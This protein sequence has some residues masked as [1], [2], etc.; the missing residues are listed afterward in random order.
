LQLEQKRSLLAMAATIAS[1]AP[2][3]AG[4]PL[5]RLFVP[6][7]QVLL[8]VCAL[9]IAVTVWQMVL[10]VGDYFDRKRMDRQGRLW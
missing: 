8:V 4:M 2:F 6:W 1:A 5:H 7:G 3:M 10:L 9:T